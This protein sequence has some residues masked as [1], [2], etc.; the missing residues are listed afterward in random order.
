MK[1]KPYKVW[2][3]KNLST[4]MQLQQY[5]ENLSVFVIERVLNMVGSAI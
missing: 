2:A 1:S 5:Y 4:D 3:H